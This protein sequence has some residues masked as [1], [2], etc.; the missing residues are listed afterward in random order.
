M[1]N[2]KAQ[3]SFVETIVP[4]KF[5]RYPKSGLLDYTCLWFQGPA[6]ALN[7]SRV[8]LGPRES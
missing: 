2:Q 7:K 8:R 6:R 5:V 1:S 4:Q 3:Q